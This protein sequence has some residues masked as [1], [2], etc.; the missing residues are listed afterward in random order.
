MHVGAAHKRL[1]HP[2]PRH[3]LFESDTDGAFPAARRHSA[4]ASKLAKGAPPTPLVQRPHPILEVDEER[5]EFGEE[6]EASA[7]EWASC[8][9]SVCMKKAWRMCCDIHDKS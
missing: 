7:G 2:A 5:R 6:A 8:L 9:M 3:V 1:I 4:A